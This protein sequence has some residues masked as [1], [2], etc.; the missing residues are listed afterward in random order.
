MYLVT[1]NSRTLTNQV[2]WPL[3]GNSFTLANHGFAVG[4]SL[5][6]RNPASPNLLSNSGAVGNNAEGTTFYVS[7]IP[8]SN[9]FTVSDSQNTTVNTLSGGNAQIYINY[10][11]NK[12]VLQKIPL[13]IHTDSITTTDDKFLFCF[14]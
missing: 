14:L 2:V 7:T 12:N 11:S 4:D 9:H 10:T 3:S 6:F 5:V 8:D 13:K 1:A